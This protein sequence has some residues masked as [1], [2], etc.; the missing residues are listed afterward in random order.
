MTRD[1][2]KALLQ[3]I[4]I[5][6]WR[7][8]KDMPRE[9]IGITLDEWYKFLG[10]YETKYIAEA[11]DLCIQQNEFPPTI[12]EIKEKISEVERKVVR[13]VSIN[14]P[15]LEHKSEPISEEERAERLRK[16]REGLR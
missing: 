5:H 3:K 6:W 10:K 14:A 1:E 13:E 12:K 11:L 15:R 4:Q 2:T 9:Y 8:F 16:I 7:F